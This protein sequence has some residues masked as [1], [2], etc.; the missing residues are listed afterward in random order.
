MHFQE[1]A[2]SDKIQSQK[3]IYYTVPVTEHFRNGGLL[4]SFQGLGVGDWG[5]KR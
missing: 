1:I 3:I 2:V 4:S 5:R